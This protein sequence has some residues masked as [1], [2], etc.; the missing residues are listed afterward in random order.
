MTL[1]NLHNPLAN[2]ARCPNPERLQKPLKQVVRAAGLEPAREFSQ[3]ILSPPFNG[4]NQKLGFRSLATLPPS[5]NNLRREVANLSRP[6]SCQ[7][8]SLANPLA[9]DPFSG[10]FGHVT[11]ATGSYTPWAHHGRNCP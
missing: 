7:S 11:F 4:C 1:A 3:R 5:T 2:P 6:L 9:F 8:W 10:H